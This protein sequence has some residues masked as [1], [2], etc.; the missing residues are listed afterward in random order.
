MRQGGDSL[1]AAD[2]EDPSTWLSTPPHLLGPQAP[3]ELPPPTDTRPQLLPFGE[4]A[5]EAFERLCHRLLEQDA[6]SP[7]VR[8]YGKRG[9][10]QAGIDVYARDRLVHGEAQPD[11]HYVS[12]QARR[13]QQLSPGMLRSSVDDFLEGKLAPLSRRFIYA[14]S[15]S[16]RSVKLADEIETLASRLR[17]ESIEFVVWDEE[18]LSARLKQCPELVDDF[19]GRAWVEHFCGEAAAQSLGIRLD[20]TKAASLRQDLDRVYRAAFGVADSGQFAF[21]WAGTPTVALR[22]RFVTPD[23]VSTTPQAASLPQ[24]MDGH[25]EIGMDEDAQALLL[26]AA[27]SN[28]IM[29]DEDAWFLRSS[30]QVQRRP[31]SRSVSER[32]PADQWLGIQSRQVIVGEP[33]AGKSTLLRYLVL[34]LL[35]GEP[36]WREVA[37]R[38]GERLPVW[39]PFHFFTQRVAGHTGAEASV[40]EALKAWLEQQDSGHVW[41]LVEDALNDERLLLVVDGLDEWISDEAGQYCLAALQTFADAHAVPLVVSTRPYGL[42]RLRLG[43]DWTHAKIAPLTPRQQRLLASHYFHAS[44][45]AD[46]SP[47]PVGV[48]ERSVDDFLAQV[49]SVSDLRAISGIPLFLVLLVGLRLSS[50]ARLPAGRFEVYD[51]AVQLFVADHPAQRRKAAAVTAPLQGLRDVQLRRVL[52]RIAFESQRRGDL[53]TLPE[54]ELRAGLH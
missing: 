48:V 37:A 32:M 6:E 20:A 9:Q 13:I 25:L 49:R 29:P 17:G 30:A 18:E 38:W 8:L 50:N 12:L 26:E 42:D 39:L 36:S 51:R 52:A 33:G 24:P 43:A 2:P 1:S 31:A 34:D 22:D 53:A 15:A 46:D 3:P 19:F 28:A 16:A 4:L 45:G 44:V 21:R 23:L 11:R 54:A 47:S 10:A 7:V 35:S 5:W 27:V 14:T 41:P 40:G